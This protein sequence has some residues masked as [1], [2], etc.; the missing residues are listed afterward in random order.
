MQ[1]SPCLFLNSNSLPPPPLSLHRFVLK[2]L[3]WFVPTKGISLKI[4]TGGTSHHIH[5]TAPSQRT[6]PSFLSLWLDQ[7]VRL[8]NR[9]CNY[10]DLQLYWSKLLLVRD[11]CQINVD[12]IE[13]IRRPKNKIKKKQLGSP[14]LGVMHVSMKHG[15]SS[16]PALL[17]ITPMVPLI[18]FPSFLPPD[19]EDVTKIQKKFYL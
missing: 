8:K 16:L 13:V 2:K 1:L 9:V 3:L 6:C 18:V 17:F 10:Q 7:E 11:E 4:L 5:H 19:W 14:R 15:S 12:P